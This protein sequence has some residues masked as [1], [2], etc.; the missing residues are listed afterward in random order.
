MAT[1]DDFYRTGVDSDN[2]VGG[3]ARIM[4]V[5][6]ADLTYPVDI[7][8]VIDLTTYQPVGLW[9]DA[10]LTQEA[11]AMT[12]SFETTDWPSQQLGVI[13]IQ[14]GDWTRNVSTSF[15]ETLGDKIMEFVHERVSSEV[16][17]GDADTVDYFGDVTDVT[18]WRV[19]ALYLNKNKAGG[20]NIIMDVF[21][22]VKRGGDEASVE[23]SRTDAQIHTT[24]W[25]PLPEPEAPHQASW[26]RI[27]QIA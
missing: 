2:V 21:P 25:R 26:Y 4:I 9:Q 20:E 27:T 15:M 17:P 7:S 16:T 12:N 8:D 18:E 23:W 24:S 19:A 10:G 11:F 13:N 6:R 1:V 3:P 22:R 5:K 14:V